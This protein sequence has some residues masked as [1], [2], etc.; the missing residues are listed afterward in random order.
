[1]LRADLLKDPDIVKRFVREA[2]A[3]AK[4]SH[5][6]IATVHMVGQTE[7]GAPFIV[8]EYI[9]GRP[10]SALLDLGK[11][12]SQSRIVHL[13]SQIASAL[14]EAHAQGIV[15]RDL[16][17]E[18]I[19]L[20]ERRGLP[21]V[22]KLVDFGIA[23]I[24]VSYAPGEDAISRMGT[25]FGTP[26]YIAPEQAS[27]QAVDGRADLYAVGV[28]M[29]ELLTGEVPFLGKTSR[30]TLELMHVSKVPSSAGDHGAGPVGEK[31]AA[32]VQRC[33]AKRP[34][35]R[36]QTVDDL[37][38]ALLDAEA[39]SSNGADHTQLV[40]PG[41]LWHALGSAKGPAAPVASRSSA[42]LPRASPT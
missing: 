9:D 2:R 42:G 41:G 40:R 6:N 18:N 22:V 16:K 26:H 10:L 15:H 33:L 27:G 39:L 11:P 7:E 28:V 35:D 37:R 38:Q 24:L 8:M 32:A 23:K 4:V 19:L 30:E 1:M 12:L 31:L 13:A 34:E 36:F 21:D 29:H 14:V 17:P 20:G 3:G 5:P 25:V